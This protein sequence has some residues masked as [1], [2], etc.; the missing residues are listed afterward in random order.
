MAQVKI[1]Y[2]KD[3]EGDT[4]KT[5]DDEVEG[6]DSTLYGV[7][8]ILEKVFRRWNVVDGDERPTLEGVRSMSVGDIVKVGRGFYFCDTIGWRGITEEQAVEIRLFT[9]FA[10]RSLGLDW[11]IEKRIIRK[12]TS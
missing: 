7:Q 1:F 4:P 9:D 5:F 2:P 6:D 8:N 11:L 10:S 3:R 12:R